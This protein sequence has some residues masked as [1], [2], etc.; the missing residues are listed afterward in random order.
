MALFP[1]F[2]DVARLTAL[3]GLAIMAMAMPIGAASDMTY[4]WAAARARGFLK[5][6]RALRR[7]GRASGGVLCGAGAAIAAT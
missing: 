5:D 7:V 2:F 1:G 3:D 4:A 6:A